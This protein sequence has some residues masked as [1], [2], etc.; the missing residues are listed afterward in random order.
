MGYDPL[1]HYLSCKNTALEVI[2][3]VTG[4]SVTILSIGIIGARKKILCLQWKGEWGEKPEKESFCVCVFSLIFF[5]LWLLINPFKS[6]IRDMGESHF[7][8]SIG[9]IYLVE[10]VNHIVW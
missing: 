9:E 6:I 4:G 2:I 3:L 10:S 8:L 7:N 5:C 1:I